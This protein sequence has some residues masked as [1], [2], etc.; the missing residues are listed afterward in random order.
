MGK[1]WFYQEVKKKGSKNKKQEKKELNDTTDKLQINS[2]QQLNDMQLLVVKL[3]Q[4]VSHV[5]CN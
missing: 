3:I 2:D 4:F 1:L 5:Y